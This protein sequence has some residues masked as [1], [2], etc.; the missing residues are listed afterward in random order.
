MTTTTSA[1]SSKSDFVLQAH[2]LSCV[3]GDRQLFSGLDLRV[4][5]G[6]CLHVRGPNGVGK[7]SL[8][9]LLTGLSKPESGEVLWKHHSITKDP[10]QYHQDLLFL[11]HRDAL[12]EDLTALE[13]I[14]MYAVL[15]NVFLPQ[16]QALASLWRF[17]LRGREDLPVQ[18]LSAG[19]KRRVLMARMAIRQ[20]KLWILDEP[21]NALD[22]NAVQDLQ[23]LIAE[24]LG[25]GGLVVLT[26]HQE[27]Q[28]PHVRIL[29]L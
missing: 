25:A 12:K 14:E 2:A 4:D 23:D 8:L 22:V 18:Y 7:T 13:N 19:Q 26:S 1:T 17:G 5:S 20:A 21:F 10:S 29:E 16:A 28:I 6:E 9:R 15:D 24:H 3:R 11:G 27:F